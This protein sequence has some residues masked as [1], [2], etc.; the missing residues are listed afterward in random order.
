MK[1]LQEN[2]WALRGPLPTLDEDHLVAPRLQFWAHHGLC[3]ASVACIRYRSPSAGRHEPYCTVIKATKLLLD[4]K[5]FTSAVLPLLM[6]IDHVSSTHITQPLLPINPV[7]FYASSLV[8]NLGGTTLGIRYP[9]A[10][11]DAISCRTLADDSERGR[12]LVVSVQSYRDRNAAASA[13]GDVTS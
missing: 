9:A 2:S 5:V 12:P 7:H 11:D 1:G 4:I 3:V 8:N 6:P 13:K 10:M